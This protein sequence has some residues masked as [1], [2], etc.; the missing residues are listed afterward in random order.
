V[1]QSN[2]ELLK[3][4]F[5]KLLRIK[6]SDIRIAT[7]KQGDQA[8]D[9]GIHMGGAFSVTVPIVSLF[10]GGFMNLDIE[11]PTRIGQDIFVLSKGHA[12]ATMASIYADF[13]Y[14]DPSILVNSR[15]VESILNGHPG[16]ILPGVHI[17]TGPLGQGVSVAHGF[18]MAGKRDPRFNVF[19]IT[20]DG[21]LQEG[22]A[23][24]AIMHAPQMR[25]DNLCM[26]VDKNEGQL[27]N[28]D[29]LIFS[30][31]NLPKQI[32]SFGWRM[33]NVD[34]TSYSAVIDALDTFAKLPRDGRPT[35]IVCNTKKGFGAFSKGLNLHKIVLSKDLYEQE[36]VLQNAQRKA[37]VG[38]YLEFH[39]G[40]TSAGK[41]SV[42]TALRAR[43]QAMN[44]SIGGS[45]G[46]IVAAPRSPRSGRV[47]ERDKTVAYDADDLPTCSEDSQIAASDVVKQCMSVFARDPKVVSVDADLASTSGLESG[48]GAVDQRRAINVGVAES[49]MMCVGEA[50]A[51]LGYNAWVSTFCPFFDWKVLRRIAVGAQERIEAMEASD[52]WLSK[53]HGLDLTFLA[54]APNFETKTNGATHM[55]NDDIIVFGGIAGLKII[56][57][58]CPNQLVSIMR[59][60]MDGNRGL[61][62]LRI[63]R[64]ASGVLY[65]ASLEFAYGRAYRPYGPA[66]GTVNFVSSG[67]G[68]HESIAA[69]RM[70]EEK[71]VIASVYDMPSFD[72]ETMIDILRQDALT[73]VA[74]QN[75]GFIWHETGQMMLRTGGAVSLQNCVAINVNKPDGSY[76]F[77]HSATY[78][79]LLSQFGLAPGQLAE[80]AL[81]RLSNKE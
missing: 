8:V 12:V 44:L 70:L 16:P 30:M 15:S 71:G 39:E 10:Y 40:L 47:P 41:E 64:S 11:D 76:H 21:E 7:L 28:P 73:V 34:G 52:G 4:G 65:P 72:Q 37:R 35:A 3:T 62:Y 22:V 38:E 9:R 17:A 61:I 29:Q 14:F 78:E 81:E 79:Q 36:I 50:Y 13:G 68:V 6:D 18:A 42:A 27:D 80:T 19:C 45:S 23:W 59:W 32:E 2:D 49:N 1:Y 46:E 26:L 75:N 48:V 25:L 53:G 77:L 63:M 5:I 56:D 58:S 69:A 57:V 31:D 54:T 66:Q 20:G 55:G 24:E 74:E 67:R 33:L 60:I 43:A 51:V